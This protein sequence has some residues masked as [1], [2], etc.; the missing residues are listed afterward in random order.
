M[1]RHPHTSGGVSKL[2]DAPVD[3]SQRLFLQGPGGSGKT[4][5]V[6]KVIAQTYRRYLPGSVV[7]FASQNSS[8]RLISGNT[9]HY[10][11]AMT[12]HQSLTKGKPSKAAVEKLQK[13]WLP[14]SFAFL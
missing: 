1:R 3:F 12:R 8:A 5:C 2:L 11:A 13:L 6:N 14:V 4:W 10:M 7:C 9:M